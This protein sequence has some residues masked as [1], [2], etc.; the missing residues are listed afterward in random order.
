MS[1]SLSLDSFSEQDNIDSNSALRLCKPTLPMKCMEMKTN[2]SKCT[3]K[4]IA[5]DLG[6]ADSTLE[7]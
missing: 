5:K 7:R 2:S 1:S 4:Q 3:R 6:C